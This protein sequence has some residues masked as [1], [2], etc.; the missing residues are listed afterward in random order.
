[1]AIVDIALICE[2]GHV[3]N[4]YSSRIKE[5]NVNYCKDCGKKAISQCPKC[6]SPIPGGLVTSEP[7]F[8][9]E[10]IKQGSEYTVPNFCSSCG[11]AFP[12]KPERERALEDVINELA[13]LSPEEK[14]KLTKAIPDIL[15]KTARTPTASMHFKKAMKTIGSEG[16]KV[17]RQVILEVAPE[18]VKDMLGLKV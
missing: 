2:S 6:H 4:A 18:V 7:A 5:L 11:T 15:I 9:H 14:A 16:G 17:L 10:L 12:W 1:M 8:L 3:I 13:N